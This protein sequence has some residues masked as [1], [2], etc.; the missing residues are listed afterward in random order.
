MNAMNKNQRLFA[1]I[2]SVPVLLLIP[3]IGMQLSSDVNWSIFDF[4]V[5]G[6]L[7][8]FVGVLFEFVL[9][10]VPSKKN[11]IALV[12]TIIIAFLILWAELAVG[13][14]NSPIAGQ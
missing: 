13:I 7:L 8:L 6:I 14:F 12:A 4:L 1:I 5:M 10:K 11:R 2:L 9:R 3:L